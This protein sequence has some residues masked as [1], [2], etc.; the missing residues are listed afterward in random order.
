VTDPRRQPS[1]PPLPYRLWWCQALLGVGFLA[2]AVG[3]ASTR[4][5]DDRLVLAIVWSVMGVAQLGLGL[6]NRRQGRL[7]QRQAGQIRD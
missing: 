2:V 6:Y 5:G 1:R 7:A 3:W 4:E